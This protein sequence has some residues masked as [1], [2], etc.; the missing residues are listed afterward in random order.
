[1]RLAI[2]DFRMVP[3]KEHTNLIFDIVLPTDLRGQETH[4]RETLTRELNQGSAV[5]Y[6]PVITFDQGNFN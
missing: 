3:G 1:M 6:Y 2:H 4:I 5:T